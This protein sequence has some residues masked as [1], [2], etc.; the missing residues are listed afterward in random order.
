[1]AF[2]DSSWKYFPNTGRSTVSYM[3]FDKYGPVDHSTHVKG[4]V[5]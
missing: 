2:S 5:A 4:P 1:M 3:I